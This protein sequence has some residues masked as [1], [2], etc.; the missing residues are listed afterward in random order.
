[1]CRLLLRVPCTLIYG[2]DGS[3]IPGRRENT[4][5]VDGV[6]HWDKEFKNRELPS[7]IW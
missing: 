5:S 6:E 4:R 7:S 1:M 2:S 3:Y